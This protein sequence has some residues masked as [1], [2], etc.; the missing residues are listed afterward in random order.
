MQIKEA[1]LEAIKN[2]G[3]TNM[4]WAAYIRADNLDSELAKLQISD[5]L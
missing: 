3:L 2:E 4:R 5:K 1:L